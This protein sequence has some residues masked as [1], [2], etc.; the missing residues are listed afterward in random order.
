MLLIAF[1][2]C[3]IHNRKWFTGAI[4]EEMLVGGDGTGGEDS[5]LSVSST[6]PL[7]DDQVSFI[8]GLQVI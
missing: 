2:T 4:G 5:P 1:H 6:D 7:I 8:P 3:F